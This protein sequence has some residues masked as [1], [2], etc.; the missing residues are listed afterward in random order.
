MSD[1][2]ADRSR[3]EIEIRSLVQRYNA[4]GDAGRFDEFLDLFT[5]DATY[6]VA[7]RDAPF[8]GHD[9]IRQLLHEA[10]RDLRDWAAGRPFHLRHFTSTHEIDFDGSDD[11]RG[12]LY[13]QCLMPHGLD[14]WG[15]YCDRYQRVDGAWR[16]ARRTEVRDGMVDGGWCHRLWGPD[17]GYARP[18][19]STRTGG[20]P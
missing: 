12:R 10:N 9:G 5:P 16:I 4:L 14:H 19:Q 17:G 13:Y 3:D 15:R 2:L 11:A 6:V 20:C 7:G 1:A 8:V 18:D